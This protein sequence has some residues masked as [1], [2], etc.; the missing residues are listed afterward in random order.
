[1][2]AID[3]A[4]DKSTHVDLRA[5]F[6]RLWRRKWWLL[7]SIAVGVLGGVA[8]AQ[9]IRPVYR[10]TLVM[11][12]AGTGDRDLSSALGNLGGLASLA[13]LNLHDADAQ[14]EEA[15]AVL[16]SRG[17]AERF[18][19][20]RNLLPEIFY[21]RWDASRKQWTVAAAKQPT[22][23]K[24]WKVFDK[25]IRKVTRDQ[26][27]G[28]VTLSIVWVDR[29][30]A[31]KWA[32]DL[33]TQLNREMRERAI[34]VSSTRLGYLQTELAKTSLVET[35]NAIGRLIEM[36]YQQRMLASVSDEFA[37]RIVD[38]AMP[39]EADDPVVSKGLMLA[40]GIFIGVLVGVTGAMFEWT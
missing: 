35:R 13:G 1:M 37:F 5:L 36:Q 10:A 3:T 32:N 40:A 22:L 24:A 14:T 12:P 33:A 8:A 38:R 18:I 23:A 29:V 16:S 15:L 34:S 39:A 25:N 27:S 26:K 2:T 17:F 6:G 30:E 28:L 19:E 31:A 9:F 7:G 11:I 21:K 4:E 20:E